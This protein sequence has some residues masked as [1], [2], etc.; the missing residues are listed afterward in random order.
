MSEEPV[1]PRTCPTCGNT[2]PT[3]ARY[4]PNCGTRLDPATT[5]SADD[6]EDALADVLEGPEEEQLADSLTVPTTS[7]DAP[8][9]A[10]PPTETAAPAQQTE[11]T[12]RS[13]DWVEPTG[14]SGTWTAPPP[15]ATIPT[16]PR[17]NRTLW[18]I[19]AIVGF[20]VFCCCGGFFAVLAL[21][22]SDTAFQQDASNFAMLWIR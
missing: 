12:V 21:A 14:Q 1:Q 19:L 3:V 2:V 10:L 13:S 16:R 7:S 20:L 5:Y 22:E 8:T 17:G 6:F 15:T 18:I 4:C 9:E 11:W